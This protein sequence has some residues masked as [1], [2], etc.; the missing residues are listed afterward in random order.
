MKSRY[1]LNERAGFTLIEMLMVFV[2]MGSL[3]SIA[4]PH[5]SDYTEKALAAQCQANR[6]HIEL[7]EQAYFVENDKPNLEIDDKYSCPAG[8]TY[9]WLVMDPDDPRYPQIGCSKHFMGS[10]PE[11]SVTTPET[12]DISPSQLI[13]DL[14]TYVYNLSLGKSLTNSLISKL[15]NA[16]KDLEKDKNNKT[17]N[18][19]N[20]LIKTVEKQQKKNS[21][22]PEESDTLISKANEIKNML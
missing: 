21:I 20:D 1:C 15:N 14:I 3:A 8:G 13:D 12:E 22:T 19:L 7:E 18:N 16:I 9:V 10:L 17:I 6:Y 4:I 5:Y 2:I 11:T